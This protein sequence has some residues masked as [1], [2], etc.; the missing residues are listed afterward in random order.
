M[1]TP[2]YGRAYKF[3]QRARNT[4]FLAILAW[5][6]GAGSGFWWHEAIFAYLLKPSGGL[7]SPFEG[8]KPI[9]LAPQDAFGA[10]LD[11]AKHGGNV[12]AVPVLI[13]GGL[14]M[15]KAYAPTRWWAFITFYSAWAVAAFIAGNVFVYYVMMPVSLHFL[16]NFASSVVVPSVTLIN[17]MTLML[18]L[19]LWM[20]IAFEIPLV[21]NLLAKLTPFR[22]PTFLN[23]RK[24]WIP[25]AFIFAA[26]ITPSL[27]GTLTMFVAIPMLLLYEVGLL[28]AWLEHRDEGNYP[29]DLANDVR[30]LLVYVFFI[31]AGAIVGLVV[32]VVNFVLGILKG[33]Y[34][35]IRFPFRWVYRKLRSMLGG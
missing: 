7:L 26:L 21:M 28:L 4:I 23:F 34:R 15:L 32:A 33:I 30:R 11:L 31:F 6:I 29:K 1:P 13:V 18:S 17:Y 20:G 3:G 5:F 25:T 10:T 8:G 9:T 12:L 35:V 27:D 19:L 24:W 2:A 22:Y 14:S 16:L